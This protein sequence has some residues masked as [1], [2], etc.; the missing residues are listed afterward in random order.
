MQFS[1]EQICHASPGSVYAFAKTLTEKAFA[2]N[3]KES[4]FAGGHPVWGPGDE[5]KIVTVQHVLW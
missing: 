1:K 4:S 5:I 2:S 3:S